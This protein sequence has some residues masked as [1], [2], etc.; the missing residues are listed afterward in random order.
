MGGD[1][2]KSTYAI[3]LSETEDPRFVQLVISCAR[4]I[5]KF[6]EDTNIAVLALSPFLN[7]DDEKRLSAEG[8]EIWKEDPIGVANKRRSFN[9]FELSKV[10]AWRHT[11]YDKV[12]LLDAD[13]LA[14]ASNKHV[15][16]LPGLSCNKGPYAP[17]N[18]SALVLEPSEEVYMDLINLILWPQFTIQ[19]GWR[20]YGKFKWKGKKHNWNFNAAASTQGLFFYYFDLLKQSANYKLPLCFNHMGNGNDKFKNIKKYEEQLR[21]VGVEIYGE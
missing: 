3:F 9:G 14:T 18:C 11:E 2:L 19:K 10:R 21:S 16:D 1:D 13:N 17:L 7:S 15:F 4:S 5:R 6:D 12:C 20:D 8:L